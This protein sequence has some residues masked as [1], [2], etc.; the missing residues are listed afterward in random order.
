VT[1]VADYAFA[2]SRFV[3]AEFEEFLILDVSHCCS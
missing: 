2:G 3:E 1:V